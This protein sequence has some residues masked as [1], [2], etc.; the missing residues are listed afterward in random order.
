[1][2]NAPAFSPSDLLYAPA[3]PGVPLHWSYV[4]LL[5][6]NFARHTRFYGQFLPPPLPPR[7]F[8]ENSG[9]IGV[10]V[11]T[12]CLLFVRIAKFFEK[13]LHFF[14]DSCLEQPL[15]FPVYSLKINAHIFFYACKEKGFG[16]SQQPLS[17]T[18]G[19]MNQSFPAAHTMDGCSFCA[20]FSPLC[21]SA[22]L[23]VLDTITM[24]SIFVIPTIF[25]LVAEKGAYLPSILAPSLKTL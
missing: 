11:E 4:H 13:T 21:A 1:M 18:Y 9:K 8:S 23:V 6:C 19:Y 17:P 20:H 22:H 10:L 5:C 25:S 2:G 24:V 3:V 14:C 12:T 15:T 16:M 7:Y